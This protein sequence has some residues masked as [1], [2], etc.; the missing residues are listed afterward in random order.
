MAF[1]NSA[2]TVLQTL[3]IALGAGLGAWGV[4][5]LLD[6]R[7]LILNPD[8]YS[9]FLLWML[10]ELFE[11]LPEVGDADKP[12]LVFFFDEAHM[13]FAD[14]PRVLVQKIEQVVKLIRSKGVGVYFVTQNPSDIPDGVLAQLSNRVQHALRAYTPNEQ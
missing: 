4:I 8:M 10:S 2:V 6:C 11:R 13:L 7:K 5:N 9:T 3:V 12:K 14:A 1:F